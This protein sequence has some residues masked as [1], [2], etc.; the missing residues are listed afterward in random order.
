MINKKRTFNKFTV[1]QSSANNSCLDL[2][3][4]V[5]DSPNLDTKKKHSK[6]ELEAGEAQKVDDIIGNDIVDEEEN[7]PWLLEDKKQEEEELK[8][9][10]DDIDLEREEF[11]WD[12]DDSFVENEEET[13]IRNNFD[14]DFIN[15]KYKH[16]DFDMESFQA[17][18]YEGNFKIFDI[19]L[20]SIKKEKPKEDDDESLLWDYGTAT[21]GDFTRQLDDWSKIFGIQEKAITKLLTVLNKNIPD[22]QW[23]LRISNAGNYLSSIKNYCVEDTRILEF[24]ICP[25][26]GCSAFV[27][28]YSKNIYCNICQAN[29][30]LKC[31]HRDCR[32]KNYHECT[33]SFKTRISNKSLF[34]RPVTSLIYEL[35][36]N[37][38]FLF[39]MNYTFQDRSKKNKYM[40]CSDGSTYQKNL[41]Q[42]VEK[43][44]KKFNDTENKPEMINILLGQ[45]YDGCMIYKKQ[46]AVFWPLNIII[47]NLP[48]SYRIKLGIGMFLISVFT[49]RMKSNAEDFFLRSLYVGELLKLEEGILLT[50]NNRSFFVQVRMI[51]TI[52]DTIAV[53]DMLKCQT[54]QAYAGCFM[55]IHGEGYRGKLG[56]TVYIGHRGLTPLRHWLR[57]FGQTRKCCPPNFYEIDYFDENDEDVDVYAGANVMKL[58]LPF[59]KK[60]KL[61]VCDEEN[62]ENIKEFCAI[63]AN[64]WIWYSDDFSKEDF[65]NDLWYANCDY[66]A[67]IPYTR[68]TNADYISNAK[69]ARE[70]RKQNPDK[71]K[72]LPVNGIYDTWQMADLPYSDIETDL[73]WGPFHT[74]M[75]VSNNMIEN[76]KGERINAKTQDIIKYSKRTGTHPDLYK[77]VETIKIKKKTTTFK[78]V[79]NFKWEI[80]TDLQKKVY[81]F[82]F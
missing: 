8:K 20:E 25:A 35:L 47:L 46:Y 1:R 62:S 44:H 53:Q 32:N 15:G 21:K 17:M 22:I 73:C 33:H 5:F 27:G 50:V 64:R 67:K 66:R 71:K 81:K 45:F 56:R 14:S 38:S 75:N 9:N 69:A 13:L 41:S 70:W 48:P 24:H 79:E 6:K 60:E 59:L 12:P 49:A 54:N 34:F 26:K 68:K 2:I 30:F 63:G 77:L 23:P 4:Q 18:S 61:I 31:S 80:D 7:D 72:I 74:L 39:A 52:L 36:K 65:L 3:N 76:W 58:H 51:L 29:R 55:C 42:M 43:Y 78:P 40:D 28:N 11:P 37:E 57:Y 19:I 82:L 16:D 10:Q